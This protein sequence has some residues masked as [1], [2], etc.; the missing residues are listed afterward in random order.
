MTPRIFAECARGQH[1]ECPGFY[2]IYTRAGQSRLRW[3]ACPDCRHR[4][5]TLEALDPSLRGRA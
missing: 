2:P 3:C 4:A 1:A 5:R